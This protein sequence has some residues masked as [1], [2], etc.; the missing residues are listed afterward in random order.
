VASSATAS[1]LPAG[2]EESVLPS[3]AVLPFLCLSDDSGQ[4]YFADG[5]VEDIITALSRF[6]SFAVIA[7]NS[8]FVYKGRSVDVRQVA[9]DLGVRYVLEG[10]VRRLGNRLRIGAQLVDGASG[11]H[12]WAD[13]FDGTLD[14]VFDFQDRITRTVAT[15]VEPLVQTAEIERARRERP[16]SIAAYDIYLRALPSL[17]LETDDGNREACLLLSR[18]LSLDPD[19]AVILAYVAFALGHRQ[20]MG[21]PP[22]AEDDTD[23]CVAASRRS[24]DHATD[25][26]VVMAQ[27]AMTL[28]HTMKDYDRGMAVIRVA[29]EANPNS[30]FVTCRAGIAHLHC[31]TLDD[32]L[33][34]FHRTDRLS[35]CDPAAHYVLTGIAH[36]AM[37]RG[38]YAE[39][40]DWSMRSL[41][42]NQ[43]FPPTYWML[44]AANAQLGLMAEARRFASELRRIVSGVST[45]SIWAGQPQKNPDRMAAIL[46]GLRLA[47][48][49]DS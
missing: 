18:A 37:I 42:I 45:A 7:R 29:E 25:D 13:S 26:A 2:L 21:W 40:L 22:V 10:S 20:T 12:L 28:I 6:K 24:L 33:A 49:D 38:N 23:R 41:A 31:G 1:I 17:Y 8:S 48:L 15:L 14:D 32:A 34:W 39:A 4:D 5:V 9:H 47:G 3:L 43:N 30:V 19:N 44:A 46:D 11:G 35:P 16:K 27:G 36:L